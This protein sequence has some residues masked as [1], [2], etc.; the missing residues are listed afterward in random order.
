MHESI[1]LDT[2]MATMTL[3]FAASIVAIVAKKIKFPFT[4]LLVIIGLILGWASHQIS[5]LHPL[6]LLKMTPEVVLFIF[7][8][9]LI[10][11]SAFNLDAKALIKNIVPIL[12]LAIP[13]LL[14]STATVGLIIHY[15]LGLPLG[16]AL[17]FGSLISATDP[18]AVVALFKEIGAPKR[19]NLL[20]EGES[21]FNDG[22]ALVLFKIILGVII[23]GNFTAS[24]ITSGIV[25]FFIVFIGGIL[26]GT[27]LGVI[28]AKTIEIVRN[29]PL[30]EI[31]LT[32]ILAHTAFITAEHLFHVSGIMSTVAAGI[33]MGGYGRTKIS[34]SIEEHMESF[35]EYFAF[36]CNSLIFLLVGLSIDM[37]L[38]AANIGAI[39]V[40]SLAI[41]AARAMAVYSLVPLI[42]KLKLVE[43]VS[44]QFQTVIFWGGLR[45]ALAIAIALSIPEDLEER[46]FIL[47]LT[48]G[49][50]LFTLVVNG[51][52]INPLMNV[53]GLNKF[54][55][56]EKFERL[57]ALLH[58]KEHAWEEMQTFAARGAISEKSLKAA[59]EKYNN[60][61]ME[62]K[63]ALQSFRAGE[64][65]IGMEGEKSMV[66]RHTLMLERINYYRLFEEGLLNEDNLKEL[67]NIIDNELDRIKEGREVMG[68][69]ER[70][71][72]S[73]L[74]AEVFYKFLGML[75]I[76]RP[77]SMKY[78]TGKIAASYERKRARLLAFSSILKELD[79]MTAHKSYSDEAINVAREFYKKLHRRTTQ[80]LDILK[81]EYPEYVEKVEEGILERCR[82][83]SELE[84]FREMYE[85]GTITDK[86]LK[87]QEEEIE[88]SIRKMKIRPVNELLFPPAD[89][90]ARVPCFEELGEKDIT[91]LTSKLTALSF[92]PG[93]NIVRE[94]DHGDSLFVIGRGRVDVVTCDEKG[95]EI[96]LAKLKAGQFFGEVA[97]LHPQPRTATVKAST[98]ATLLELSRINLMPYL[99][100][101]PHLKAALEEAYKKRVLNTRLSHVHAFAKLENEERE[102]I[103]AKMEYAQIE[104][105][106]PLTNSVDR[107]YLIKEG[108]A[109]VIKE[110]QRVSSLSRGGHFGENALFS[111]SPTGERIVATSPIEV[112]SLSC[113][114]LEEVMKEVPS[115]KEKIK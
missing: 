61:V 3:L 31:T 80:R 50:V 30:V 16:I 84:T 62:I 46:A 54:S 37:H 11:E 53:L 70:P 85:H 24:T 86:V 63:S 65:S 47:V 114:K 14:L 33:T 60:A 13:A 8:P 76:F 105:G 83:N 12:T 107:L 35:W 49:V 71:P 51:L 34:P 75:I 74:V 25:E 89:L 115:I 20:V 42:G 112:Y 4:I 94:G 18:V 111:K 90:I 98:P 36:I 48:L 73:E 7:L 99:E 15:V 59:K 104:S 72:F 32:T 41:I 93:E 87:E 110:G 1:I 45:G 29:D 19:L 38:F 26:T 109:E 101:L 6:T 92:L 68:K 97:L 91:S 106:N 102:A 69:G 5:A 58:S 17:L 39:L 2:V 55:V 88:R 21:L 9:A 82:L 52:S 44:V 23:L 57:Q 77:L 81:G 79:E 10:F 22:T 113:E 100:E 66:T 43:K 67:L 103:A 56:A 28:F 78:K 108:T 95:K 40:A 64:E 27:I 96:F